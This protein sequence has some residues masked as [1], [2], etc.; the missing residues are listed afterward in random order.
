MQQHAMMLSPLLY[1][2][3]RHVLLLLAAVQGGCHMGGR[4]VHQGR[5]GAGAARRLQRARAAPHLLRPAAHSICMGW[6]RHQLV[7]L[8]SQQLWLVHT[9]SCSQ[10]YA[11]MRSM[12]CTIHHACHEGKLRP[13]AA[14][15]HL[16]TKQVASVLQRSHTGHVQA[17]ARKGSSRRGCGHWSGAAT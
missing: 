11:A 16:L 5:N 9:G 7:S 3:P 4:Q 13:T 8:W 6:S 1:R 14:T 15:A 2:L 10:P 17:A 12:Y